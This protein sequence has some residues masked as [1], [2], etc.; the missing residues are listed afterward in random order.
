MEKLYPLLDWLEIGQALDWLQSLT[1]SAITSHD[2]ISLC[3]AKHCDV[4]V[5]LREPVKGADEETWLVDVTGYGIQRVRNPIAL[6]DSG[7]LRDS[8]LEFL[9]KA[10]WKDETGANVTREITWDARV[11]ML[12]IFPKFKPADIRSLANKMN[13]VLTQPTVAELELA[14]TQLERAIESKENAWHLTDKY[15]TE[16]EVLR[17]TADQDRTSREAAWLRAEQAERE[18]AVLRQQLFSLDERLGTIQHEAGLLQVKAVELRA[19]LTQEQVAREAAENEVEENKSLAEHWWT[20]HELERDCRE[21]TQLEVDQLNASIAKIDAVPKPSYLLAVAALLEMLKAPVERARP[22][23][24]NQ[25]SIKSEILGRFDWRGLRDR[26]LDE[27]FSAA[28]K[29]RADA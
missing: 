12:N 5:D 28:N 10:T 4:Y 26:N 8:R 6:V 1:E 27:I 20:Q 24:M 18:A 25:A 15:K 19:L 13:G 7:E 3:D 21:R 29:A 2:L 9:G 16:L 11:V 23:G 14:R 17:E 22:Q